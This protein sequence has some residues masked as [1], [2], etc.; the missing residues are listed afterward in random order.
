[1]S[2][3]EAVVLLSGENWDSNLSR[4][5]LDLPSVEN[6]LADDVGPCSSDYWKIIGPTD[7]TRQKP[8]NA[9]RMV[10]NGNGNIT[11]ADG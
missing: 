11:V 3:R 7:E 4:G 6:G 8:L 10:D 1:M 9:L 2:L 5:I